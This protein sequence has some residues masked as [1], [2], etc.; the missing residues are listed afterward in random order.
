[1]VLDTK[2]DESFPLGQFKINC[3]NAPFRLDRSS[4]WGSIM[5]FVW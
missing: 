2:T 5:L 4:N 1:M 3:F